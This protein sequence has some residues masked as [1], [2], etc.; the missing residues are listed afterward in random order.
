[1]G[2]YNLA[3]PMEELQHPYIASL[4]AEGLATIS[5]VIM[6]GK[7]R[8]HCSKVGGGQEA[9]RRVWN[10]GPGWDTPVKID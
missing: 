9:R 2:P 4:F 8:A 7:T 10:M 5:V 3:A 1:M 6:A